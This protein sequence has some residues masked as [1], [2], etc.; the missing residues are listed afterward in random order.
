MRRM[1]AAG[2]NRFLTDE[3]LGSRPPIVRF[4]RGRISGKVRAPMPTLL[5]RASAS[6][7]FPLEEAAFALDPAINSFSAWSAI[8]SDCIVGCSLDDGG[9]STEVRRRGEE[10]L[11]G[12]AT[13][14]SLSFREDSNTLNR[15]AETA[16]FRGWN[17]CSFASESTSAYVFLSGLVYQRE[18]LASEGCVRITGVDK[19]YRI[20]RSHGDGD[21]SEAGLAVSRNQQ[22]NRHSITSTAS[23]CVQTSS[24]TYR[25]ARPTK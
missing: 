22:S 8:V 10:E 1:S 20:N 7:V 21:D 6:G 17:P 12:A 19:A 13:R 11:E 4:S 23:N 24:K 18:G 9:G 15:T 3:R 5:A 16:S 25:N 14:C 2:S